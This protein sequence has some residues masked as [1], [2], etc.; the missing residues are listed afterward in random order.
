MLDA[1]ESSSRHIASPKPISKL[2]SH[3]KIDLPNFVFLKIGFQLWCKTFSKCCLVLKIHFIV[4]TF[5]FRK[6]DLYRDTSVASSK[7]ASFPHC[8]KLY[9]LF[10]FF[11]IFLSKMCCLT[12]TIALCIGQQY[13]DFK[14]F[15]GSKLENSLNER[16]QIYSALF[17]NHL[18]RFIVEDILR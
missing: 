14:I 7:K 16:C 9:F 4:A 6:N 13:L 15:T 3:L 12:D 2:F 5:G 10:I 11:N 8:S 18:T 17:L 1:V